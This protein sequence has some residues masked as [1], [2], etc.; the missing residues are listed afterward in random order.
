VFEAT[1]TVDVTDTPVAALIAATPP[2]RAEVWL[3]EA[4]RAPPVPALTRAVVLTPARLPHSLRMLARG[5]RAPP[6]RTRTS[7]A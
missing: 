6:S 3:P 7:L 4:F 2:T 1:Q 5:S